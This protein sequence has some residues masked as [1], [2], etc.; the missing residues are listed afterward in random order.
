MSGVAVAEL[1]ALFTVVEHEDGTWITTP[2]FTVPLA[3]KIAYMIEPTS[4]IA[5]RKALYGERNT[6]EISSIA[7]YAIEEGYRRYRM[8]RKAA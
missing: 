3:E 2:T 7:L 5:L 1:I 4:Q 8:Q 6:E